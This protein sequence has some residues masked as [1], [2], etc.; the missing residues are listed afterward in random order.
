MQGFLPNALRATVLAALIAIGLGAICGAP[1][2]ALAGDPSPF[3]RLAGRWI[4]E[5]RF[6]TKDGNT[7][8]VK[9]RV[10]YIVSGTSHDDL[11]Q[12]IRCAASSDTIEVQSL[13]MHASGR[14][15]GTWKELSRDMNGELSG[16]VTPKGF[17]VAVK[18][19][20]LNANMAIILVND[21]KQVVEIQF[22]NNSTLVGLTLVLEKR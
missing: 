15:T 8:T 22:I 9:C 17:R 19:T 18:G 13:V 10:T 3:D 5:G 6:G 16:E 2:L 14:L 1:R 11:R 20:S 4:G 7:E 12:T 21:A